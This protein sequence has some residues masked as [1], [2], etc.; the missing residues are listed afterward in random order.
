MISTTKCITSNPSLCNTNHLSMSI[1]SSQFIF[2]T[3]LMILIRHTMLNMTPMRK[4]KRSQFIMS[5]ITNL[6]I[7]IPMHILKSIHTVISLSLR[8]S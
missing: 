8:S 4:S 2:T 5:S 3:S 7:L 1:R 6:N